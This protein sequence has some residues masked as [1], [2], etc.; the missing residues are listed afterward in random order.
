MFE[1]EN[2]GNVNLL[3]SNIIRMGSGWCKWPYKIP[4]KI[5]Y[6]KILTCLMDVIRKLAVLYFI[7]GVRSNSTSAQNQP[8][9]GRRIR[10]KEKVRTKRGDS[11]LWDWVAHLLKRMGW[12]TASTEGSAKTLFVGAC[13]I[14]D[15]CR[16]NANRINMVLIVLSDAPNAAFTISP[17]PRSWLHTHYKHHTFISKLQN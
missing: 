15:D 3:G 10:S 8:H 13:K 17:S 7:T 11:A 4:L 14:D 16:E 6:A 1:Q 5:W 2:V 12:R 9:L